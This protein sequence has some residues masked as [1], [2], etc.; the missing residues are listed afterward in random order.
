M[1][2]DFDWLSV[3]AAIAILA[4]LFLCPVAVIWWDQRKLRLADR[5]D[6]N[7]SG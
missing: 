6:P 3:L 4:L 1:A 7:Q 5:A 2:N